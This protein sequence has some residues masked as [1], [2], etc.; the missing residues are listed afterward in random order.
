MP[1]T[2]GA[3]DGTGS[4]TQSGR[5]IHGEGVGGGH[6]VRFNQFTFLVYGTPGDGSIVARWRVLQNTEPWAK[7][8]VMIRESLAARFRYPRRGADGL[9][10]CRL[11]RRGGRRRGPRR[12]PRRCRV[13][14]PAYWVKLVRSGNTFTAS[15]SSNGSSWTVIGTATIAMAQDIYIGLAVTS[16]DVNAL[17]T[18][19][20]DN[21]AMSG[22]T[23]PM[24][25]SA[26]RLA[27]SGTQ[28]ISVATCQW[29]STY[30]KISSN[31][32]LASSIVHIF[33]RKFGSNE[34]GIAS[35]FAILST[36]LIIFIF[37]ASMDK[38]TPER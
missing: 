18:A 35:S 31:V 5:G 14:R 28:S 20:F 29:I 19:T 1:A 9:K 11:P 37:P 38:N 10:R 7:A 27:G 36:C 4:G 13:W 3:I 17:C 12:R 24:P 8:G 26:V 34:T 33:N 22:L 23:G 15:R 25:T 30:G 16:H 32:A 6:L 2:S 21:V